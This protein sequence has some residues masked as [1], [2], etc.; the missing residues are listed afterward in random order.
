MSIIPRTI[1]L[2]KSRALLVAAALA[3]SAAGLSLPA[4]AF[5]VTIVKDT[6]L[7][8][9]QE[10]IRGF[11]SECACTA[12]EITLA[13][14]EGAGS[15][16]STK[17]DAIIAVGTGAFKKVRAVRDLPII[18]MM[19]IPSEAAFPAENMSGVSMDI[20]PDA[21]L[22]AITEL[23]PSARKIGV[24]HDPRHIGPFV[25]EASE[26]ARRRGVELVIRTVRS[27]Q[28]VPAIL[29]QM[30]P[31]PDVFWMLPDPTVVNA[32]TVEY[33]LLYS[34]QKNVPVF[35]FSLKYVEL[36]AVAALQATPFAM[37][38]QAGELAKALSEGRKGPGRAYANRHRLIINRKVAAKMGYQFD[39]DILKKA[40]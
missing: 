17:P 20:S 35:S 11:K 32:E 21:S 27:P 3:L 29:E 25:E 26:I 23:F 9:Y 15:V 18:Y 37:G 16:L 33:L 2:A 39:P 1:R 40:E 31:V 10:A 4:E 28:E 30:R 6:E 13:N 22:T 14:G 5:V 36:G 24:L 38:A 8:P 12:T 34:F 19:V 7:K